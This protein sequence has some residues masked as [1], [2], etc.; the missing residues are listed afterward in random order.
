MFLSG[1]SLYIF[2]WLKQVVYGW[3]RFIRSPRTREVRGSSD[4]CYVG[5]DI[6]PPAEDSA[7]GVVGAWDGGRISSDSL[8][9]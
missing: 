9:A 1:T 7:Q 5:T 2:I 8:L 3:L 6:S 4:I